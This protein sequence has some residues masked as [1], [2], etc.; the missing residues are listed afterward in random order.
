MRNWFKFKATD[1]SNFDK[2]SRSLEESSF[3]FILAVSY[4]IK[5]DSVDCEKILVVKKGN[6]FVGKKSNGEFCLGL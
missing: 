3:S 6:F 4:Q 2:R 5:T 1:L